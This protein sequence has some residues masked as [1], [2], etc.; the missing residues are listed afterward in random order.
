MDQTQKIKTL[1]DIELLERLTSSNEDAVYEEFVNRYYKTV[2]KECLLKCKKRKLDRHIGE[3]IA[4]D[5]FA[6]VRKSSSF[7]KSKLTNKDERKAIVGWLYRIQSNLFYDYHKSQKTKT[8]KIEFYLDELFQ[9]IQLSSGRQ[10]S[11]KR[12]IAEKIFSKLSPKQKTVI[13]KDI[14][15]KRFQKYHKTDVL[16]ELADELGVKKS[17]IRQIRGRAIKKIR[18][19]IDEING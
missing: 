1:T 10:L 19:L 6:R 9:G 7:D 5:T 15:Y 3:Q 12:D 16:D 17:S 4:H 2:K 18:D 8:E 13:L 14:E 11:D